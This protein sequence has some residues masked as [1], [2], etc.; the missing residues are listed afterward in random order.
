MPTSDILLKQ[1]I[2]PVK[3]QK[4]FPDFSVKMFLR[5]EQRS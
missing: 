5:E 2:A 1:Q 3:Y 4:Y